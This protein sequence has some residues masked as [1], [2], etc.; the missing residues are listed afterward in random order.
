VRVLY[1]IIRKWVIRPLSLLWIR[2]KARLEG[3]TV[4]VMP[5]SNMESTIAPGDLVYL[6]AETPRR[7]QV[8]AYRSPK[9]NGLAVVA[10]VVALGGDT[11]ELRGGKLL[12]NESFVEEPYIVGERAEQDYSKELVPTEVPHGSVFVLGDFRDI[13]E[14]S[15]VIGSLQE[16]VLIGA[17]VWVCTAGGA[18]RKSL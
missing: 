1:L 13:S 14:D 16:Q 18:S 15:R 9:H 6:A 5:A 4:V 11:V 2:A 3:L 10:R 8:V 7:G 17:A 12:V